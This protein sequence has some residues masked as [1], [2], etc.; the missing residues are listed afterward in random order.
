MAGFFA[1]GCGGDDD[2]PEP[3]AGAY[4]GSPPAGPAGYDDPQRWVG[5]QLRVGAWGGEIQTALRDHVWLPFSRATGCSISE[6]SADARSLETSYQE[7]GLPYADLL[8]VDAFWA[9][10]GSARAEFELLDAT[11]ADPGR[12]APV[13]PLPS[14]IPAYAYALTMSFQ[15]NAVAGLGATQSWTEWWDGARWVGPRSLPR[16][17]FGSFEVALIGDG[18]PRTELY[19][20]D[21]GR[22][23]GKLRQFD[24]SAGA[25]W[26][27]NG[28]EPVAW[29]SQGVVSFAAAWHY[30]V[31]AAQQD[32]R[33]LDFVW[34]EALLVSDYWVIPRAAPAADVALDLMRF[35]SSDEVQASLSAAIPL[36]PV[37]PGAFR[38][39]EPRPAARSPTAPGTR[40]R[41]IPVDAGW[42]A[43]N[44]ASAAEA[45]EA[46]GFGG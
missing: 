16:G 13:P 33:P 26:W 38:F 40:D 39:I 43:A 18:V 41:V 44:Q 27:Q 45:F 29:L 1:A 15:R 46:A 32:G 37:A 22:A 21:I 9:A 8:L 14:A 5:R 36:G 11:V 20:L 2:D 35:A 25:R 17:A 24:E 30:R 4:V 31:V 19:P 10:G 12:F 34:N 42:W 28:D 7:T 23:I 6:M 3:T